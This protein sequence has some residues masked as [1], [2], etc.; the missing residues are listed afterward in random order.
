MELAVDY[1]IY[2]RVRAL[3]GEEVAMKLCYGD[4]KTYL[5]VKQVV[6]IILG[7]DTT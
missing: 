2:R 4:N 7:R 5:E 6:D 3:C 1:E